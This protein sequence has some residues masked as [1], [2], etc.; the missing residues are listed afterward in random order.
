[1]VVATSPALTGDEPEALLDDWRAAYSEIPL[2][3][4]IGRGDPFYHPVRDFV[5]SVE[6]EP[7]GG[8]TAGGHTHPYWRS[9]ALDQ[10]R[11]VG[12]RLGR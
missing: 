1:V 4:D 11:F 9:V 12:D 8:V 3:V 10:L 6:P 2:R 7:A 5:D